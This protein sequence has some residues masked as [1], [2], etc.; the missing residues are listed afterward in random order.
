MIGSAKPSSSRTKYVHRIEEKASAPPGKNRFSRK[1]SSQAIETKAVEQ[2]N[3]TDADMCKQ[4]LADGYIQSYID[5][6]HLTHRSD[7]TTPLERSDVVLIRNYIVRAEESR[8]KGDTRSVHQSYMKLASLYSNKLKDWKTSIFFY[9]KC[10]ELSLLTADKLAEMSANHHL[11]I[12]YQQMRE[13][14]TARS[15][16]EKHE[17]LALELDNSEEVARANVELHKVYFT[18]AQQRDEEDSF[19]RALELY[20]R[21]LRA[22]KL[23]SDRAAEAEANGRVGAILIRKED[24]AAAIPF[25]RAYSQISTDLNDS[26]NR[27]HAS[28][29]LAAALDSLGMTEKALIELKLVSTVSEQ[30][31]D[32]MVI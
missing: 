18:L 8:R 31:G 17:A 28:S 29:L 14:S 9:E 32:A 4:M 2:V 1:N 13:I 26:E 16:H 27:C 3:L 19:D 30:A 22:A 25:L 15:F 7:M 10:Y 23:A 6:Y 20:T 12:I 21:S 24:M 11:G 5:F